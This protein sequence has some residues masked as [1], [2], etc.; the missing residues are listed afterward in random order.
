MSEKITHE[1]YDKTVKIDFYPE[2]HRYK[3]QGEQT[4]LISCTACTGMIDKSRFLIPWAV[5]LAG[6]FLREHLE[7]S[8]VNQ[9][10]SEELLPLIDEA[11]RQHTI[12]KE[13]AASIGSQVHKFAEQFAKAK[14]ESSEMPKIYPDSDEKVINGINAFID[15]ITQHNVKF[16]ASEKLVYSQRHGFVGIAD[17]IAEVDGKEVLIDYKTGKRIYNE[18]YLQVSGYML[19]FEEEFSELDGAI[20]LHFN[21]ETGEFTA[22][23][24]SYEEHLKNIPAF[25][26]CYELKKRD[27]ELTNQNYGK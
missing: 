16:H 18:A 4:Y 1:I 20:I 23:H 19:A 3:L 10:T 14:I 7:K 11:C 15:W 12:K 13:E 2:S 8:S 22:H 21:K 6:Q 24:I 27:K 9:F 25:L 26:A 17:A 5:G